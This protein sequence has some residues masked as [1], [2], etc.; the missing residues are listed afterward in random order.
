MTHDS[1][2]DPYL[3]RY[4][5]WFSLWSRVCPSFIVLAQLALGSGFFNFSSWQFLFEV[6]F[7]GACFDYYLTTRLGGHFFQVIIP[8][9]PVWGLLINLSFT[10]CFARFL[11]KKFTHKNMYRH[12]L[13]L[14][15]DPTVKWHFSK[16]KVTS[17]SRTGTARWSLSH[18]AFQ[19]WFTSSISFACQYARARFT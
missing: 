8:L 2:I 19:L 12:I 5:V 10:Y 1:V 16:R 17:S 18:L 7:W 14:W 11:L 9:R 3:A 13:S 15:D 6:L 4:L